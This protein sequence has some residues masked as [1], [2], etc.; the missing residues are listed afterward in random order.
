MI[1]VR[2]TQPS[3]KSDSNHKRH[4]Y[5]RSPIH[6]ARQTQ[7]SHRAGGAMRRWFHATETAVQA[8]RRSGSTD[9]DGTRDRVSSFRSIAH[10]AFATISSAAANLEGAGGTGHRGGPQTRAGGKGTEPY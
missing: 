9:L 2:E 3:A 10:T 6:P 4:L 5:E 1:Y 7:A 8:S